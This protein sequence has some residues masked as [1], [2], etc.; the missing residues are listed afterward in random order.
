MSET[1]RL[2]STSSGLPRKVI[3]GTVHQRFAPPYPG[4]EKRIEELSA[5]LT[6][7]SETARARY[8]RGLDLACLPEM[9]VTGGLGGWEG[10]ARARA[11]PLEGAVQSAFEAQARK[12]GCYLAVPMSIAENAE[13][14]SNAA[15]LFD[16]KG[17][18]AGMYRKIH[19]ALRKGS[20]VLEDGVT[21]GRE[22][23]VFDCDF[24]RVGFQI[25]F[26]V[27]FDR[28]WEELA[29]SGAEIVL[30]PTIRPGTAHGLT[31]ARIHRY[32]IVSSTWGRTA[33]V[34]EP[35]G[36]IAACAEEGDPTLVHEI[37]LSYARIV[38]WAG[39][40]GENGAGFK[41]KFGSKV[42]YRCYEDEGW[43]LYW[44]NDPKVS[45]GEM[46]RSIG[47]VEFEDEIER[48]KCQYRK[49]GIPE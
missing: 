19:L 37:D 7:M 10:D 32:Y 16:R 18:I 1:P 45:I 49:A 9:A 38:S 41:E 11:L 29:R 20:T 21:P 36:N 28:G 26:D 34:F 13:K 35:T 47:G 22:I 46:A 2:K 14:I 8:G 4:L 44:S 24:G 3:V 33:H 15:V 17:K 25:C 43:G 27:M 12:H 42:G 31:R 5:L 40:P 6:R 48:T 23:P 30:W 39:R